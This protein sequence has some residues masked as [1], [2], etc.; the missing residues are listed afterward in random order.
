MKPTTFPADGGLL[1]G[2][3]AIRKTISGV[4]LVW[5]PSFSQRARKRER[6]SGL[7]GIAFARCN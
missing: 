4:F 3:F 1:T 5:P 2:R 6:S 7:L